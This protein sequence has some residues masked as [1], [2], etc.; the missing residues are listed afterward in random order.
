MS[1]DIRPSLIEKIEALSP[2]ARERV[3]GYVDALLE[4][5]RG[6]PPIEGSDSSGRSKVSMS[7]TESGEEGSHRGGKTS[8]PRFQWRGALSH[9]ADEYTAEELQEKAN[10]WRMKKA[11]GY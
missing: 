9:L 7:T 2:E 1:A 10:E 8:T 4:E 6:A 11:L 3:E 5:G